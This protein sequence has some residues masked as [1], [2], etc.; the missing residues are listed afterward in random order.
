[1]AVDSF[2]P[3]AANTLRPVVRLGD[4]VLSCADQ[5][6][7]FVLDP[8][9]RDNIGIRAEQSLEATRAWISRALADSGI[10]VFTVLAD[11]AY[12]GNIVFDQSD[13]HLATARLSIYLTTRRKG[14]GTAAI[15]AAL[16]AIFTE[17]PLYKVW[18]TVHEH[19]EVAI[20]CYEK[21]GFAH[22]GRHRGEFLLRGERVDALYMGILASEVR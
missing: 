15:R 10:R 8:D 18:L 17:W 22:E 12:V 6:Y 13:R 19:N 3:T 7:D 1:M 2:M 21:V 14:I 11:G 16:K 9:I 5:M 20:R 4:L